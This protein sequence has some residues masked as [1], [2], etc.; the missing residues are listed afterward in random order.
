MIRRAGIQGRGRCQVIQ[1]PHLHTQRPE[2]ADGAKTRN[3]PKDRNAGFRARQEG[4]SQEIEEGFSQPRLMQSRSMN[5]VISLPRF[6]M[7]DSTPALTYKHL[8]MLPVSQ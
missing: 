3:P 5:T 2:E 6:N 4:A 8:I 1:P 7:T